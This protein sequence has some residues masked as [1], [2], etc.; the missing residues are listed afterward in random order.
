MNSSP[1]PKVSSV[2]TGLAWIVALIVPAVLILT[3]VQLT[4]NDWFVEFEYRTPGF[5]ADL[6]GFS[7]AERLKYSKIAIE[8]LKNDA[9]ISFL[10]EQRFPP[11]QQTPPM[12]CQFM[13]DCNLMYNERELR[14]MADVKAVVQG[15]EWVWLGLM[16]V[17][18]ALRLGAYWG[19]W[20]K[21]YNRALGRGGWLT[22]LLLGVILICVLFLFDGFFV[23]FHRIFFTGDTW[24][25]L[26]SDT[27][28][29]LFP[30]RFWRDTFITVG[31]ISGAM[32]LALGLAFGRRQTV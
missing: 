23:L 26:Y 7:R 30:E 13:D 2:T 21:A 18:L 14:H 25:F 5:P 10:A 32:G 29:R 17:L 12:S 28:I 15:A 11:G 27:L 9:D 4:L 6:F 31:A 1:K 16:A 24:L 3:A 8:Y 19:K 22:L 20:E